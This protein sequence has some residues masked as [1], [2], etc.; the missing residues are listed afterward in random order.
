MPT[1]GYKTSL[2]LE[3]TQRILRENPRIP[4][5]IHV[6]LDGNKAVYKKVRGKDAFDNAVDTIKE[7]NK[8]K[9]YYP[10]FDISIVTTVCSYNQDILEELNE[11][12]ESIH[13]HGEWCIN[14][15]RGEP[16][17]PKAKDVDLENYAKVNSLI[18]KRITNG[19][20]RGYSG[21]MTS[22]WLSAKNA[23][24]R[25]IIFKILKNEYKGGGCSAGSLGGVV[26][27]DGSVYPCE[28]LNKSVE[29]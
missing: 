21:H 7:L 19:S 1:S 20:Y 17:N 10:H 25:K 24:R 27:P 5:R 8:L 12:V 26:Y 3:K 9:L 6:S 13:P 16:T 11:I 23:A 28:I 2:I 18:D 4:F 14:F 29:N 22:G 15:I